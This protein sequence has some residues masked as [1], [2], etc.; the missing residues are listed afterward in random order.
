MRPAKKLGIQTNKYEEANAKEASLSPPPRTGLT[1]PLHIP[2]LH[3]VPSLDLL[4]FMHRFIMPKPSECVILAGPEIL[5]QWTSADDGSVLITL[6]HR[7]RL[8]SNPTFSESSKGDRKLLSIEYPS[9]RNK[10]VETLQKL[11]RKIENNWEKRMDYLDENKDLWTREPSSFF[12]WMY[13]SSEQRSFRALRDTGNKVDL[14]QRFL[15]NTLHRLNL[16]Q[17]FLQRKNRDMLPETDVKRAMLDHVDPDFIWT[18]ETGQRYKMRVL[19]RH[20]EQG[21]TLWSLW[22]RRPGLVITLGPMMSREE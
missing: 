12:G 10:E 20:L 2:I 5:L 11:R 3:P 8:T 15:R 4:H 13:G 6:R 9:Q 1:P 7:T 14:T 19:D 22:W 21:Q 18:S 16:T 17:C